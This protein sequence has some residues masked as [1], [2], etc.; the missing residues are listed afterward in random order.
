VQA[1]GLTSLM[2]SFSKT[3]FMDSDPPEVG[4]SFELMKKKNFLKNL[5]ILLGLFQ[6]MLEILP[7]SCY[8]TMFYLKWEL[9][10]N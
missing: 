5:V 4:Y 8:P 9:V 6:D 7:S 10:I 3:A 2:L 1:P